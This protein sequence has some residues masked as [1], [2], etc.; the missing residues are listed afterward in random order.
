[1]KRHVDVI[2]ALRWANPVPPNLA[3]EVAFRSLQ[4]IL[5]SPL[6]RNDG[7]SSSTITRP[8]ERAK[9]RPRWPRYLG[10]AAVVAV[11]IGLVMSLTRPAGI[12]ADWGDT[13]AEL[14]AVVQ[15]VVDAVRQGDRAAFTGAFAEGG[16][17]TTHLDFANRASCCDSYPV[18]E[19]G[20]VDSWMAVNEAWEMESDLRSCQLASESNVRC[21]VR[22]RW[23]N[24][25]MEITEEWV[26]HFDGSAIRSFGTLND[27]LEP[28]DR[29]MPLSYVDLADWEE[30]LADSDPQEYERLLVYEDPFERSINGASFWS[31]ILR[32]DP[33]LADQIRA[34]IETYVATR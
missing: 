14:R 32:Y 22:T 24:L 23:E 7:M 2:E 26:F 1:M 16:T 17:F 27:E 3:E 29:S 18:E 8:Q 20:L 10:A 25:Q 15:Q 12:S 4:D 31:T 11:A 13:P 21:S 34:S 19:A 9:N 5:G 33:A 30:W 28:A 6:G